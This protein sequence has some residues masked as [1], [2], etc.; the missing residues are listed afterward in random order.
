M[1]RIMPDVHDGAGCVIGFTAN[2]G[3]RVIPNI[4]GVDIGCGMKVCKLDPTTKI[5]KLDVLDAEIKSWIPSGRNLHEPD[6]FGKIQHK[7][8]QNA[9]SESKSLIKELK[10]YRYL[11]DANRFP[12]ALGT[13]GGGNHFIELDTDSKGVQYLVIHSGSRNLGKQVADYYQKLAVKLHQ[14]WDKMYEIQEKLIEQYKAEGRKAEI[15]SAIAELHRNFKASNPQIPNELCWLEGSYRQDYLHD[16]RICQKY[17]Y[18]N[19]YI[20]SRLIL[21]AINA[22]ILDE[23]DTI[24]NYISFDDNIIR[25][26]AISCRKDEMVIIPMNMRDGSLICIGKGNPDWNYSGPH[27][28]GRI[29]SRAQAFKTLNVSEFKSAMEGIYTT[30]ADQST[31]DE[32]PMVYKPMQEIIDNIRD[33]VEVVDIIKPIYNFKAAE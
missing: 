5:E 27:G 20:M 24:H 30:T 21:N 9:Y 19:R 31:L 10:C 28:A 22:K 26:G 15:Q 25:K 1:V 11:K 12:R 13:L 8:I 6:F 7:G 18:A 33:T 32:A 17:A 23:F 2:L 14:G 29:M 4:V 16:M 3:D